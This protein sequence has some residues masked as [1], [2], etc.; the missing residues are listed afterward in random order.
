MKNPPLL[1]AGAVA[2]LCLCA[3]AKADDDEF[4][5][6]TA[7]RPVVV[8]R[9]I[10][11]SSHQDRVIYV[12]PSCHVPPVVTVNRSEYLVSANPA[13]KRDGEI[14]A[15][16]V[17]DSNNHVVRPVKTG[18]NG[19]TNHSEQQADKDSKSADRKPE[20]KPQEPNEPE[21]A[22]ALDRL[23]VQAQKEETIRL[24]EPGGVEPR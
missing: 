11:V 17:H 15:S 10:V 16:T 21:D 9:V 1:V 4:P 18:R 2:G 19:D 24:T 22:G 3:I 14:S 23:T 5:F 8:R 6:R 20:V 7:A 12:R 13:H